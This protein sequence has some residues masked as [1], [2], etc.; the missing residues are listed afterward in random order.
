M[1]ITVNRYIQRGRGYLPT[2]FQLN[3]RFNWHSKIRNWFLTKPLHSFLFWRSWKIIELYKLIL[4]PSPSH[5]HKAVKITTRRTKTS[6][7]KKWENWRHIDKHIS[8][9][10]SQMNHKF[11]TVSKWVNIPSRIFAPHIYS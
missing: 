5:P 10:M 7:K 4:L 2:H 6:S 3:I 8:L 9:G 11:I 1:S